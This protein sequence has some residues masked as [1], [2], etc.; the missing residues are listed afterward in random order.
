[1]PGATGAANPVLTIAAIVE[2][3]LDHLI[4]EFTT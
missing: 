1:M 4:D 3:C 2:R